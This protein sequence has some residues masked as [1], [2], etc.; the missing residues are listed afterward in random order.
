MRVA[1]AVIISVV[2]LLACAEHPTATNDVTSL[3]SSTE[4]AGLSNN[5][6]H[7][8]AAVPATVTWEATAGAL[9]ASRLTSPIVAGRGYGLL[10]IAQYAA[11]MAASPG[12]DDAQDADDGNASSPSPRA[13]YYAIRGAVAGAS[14]QV[15]RYLFPLDATTIDA[16]LAR[17]GAAGSPGVQQQFAQ[18]VAIGRS[19]GDVVVQ[20]GRADGFT[21]PDGTPRVWDP[22]SLLTGPTLWRM[23]ADATPHV[24]SGFQF[25]AMRPY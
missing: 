25:P 20:R 1:P 3:S 23:D 21:N 7:P 22:N 24:P 18:G 17:E 6:A 8:I 12:D 9:A 4:A 19:I 13:H 10:G 2:T 5:P 14:A 15:L 11:V 16:Q